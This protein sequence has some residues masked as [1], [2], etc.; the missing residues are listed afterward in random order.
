MVDQTAGESA[1]ARTASQASTS[2]RAGSVQSKS[3]DPAGEPVQSRNRT[4][5][6]TLRVNGQIIYR[7][8]DWEMLGRAG[9]LPVYTVDFFFPA[10][11]HSYLA[12]L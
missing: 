3:T 6:Q 2:G 7:M 5:G 9:D 10:V 1:A 11:T 8:A 12:A 4:R